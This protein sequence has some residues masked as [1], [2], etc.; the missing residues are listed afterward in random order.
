MIFIKQK[1]G[2][3]AA[4]LA[5]T[6]SGKLALDQKVLWF[7]S[8][9]S[10]IELEV[11]AREQIES[12]NLDNLTIMLFDERYGPDGH[13][14]SNWQQLQ[15]AGFDFSGTN[16][17]PVLKG[18]SLAESTEKFQDNLARELKRNDFIIATAGVGS[19]GHTSGLLPNCPALKSP[20]LAD[21]Y[22][23]P[24]YQRITTTPKAIAQLNEAVVGLSGEEKLAVLEKLQANVPANEMP[25]QLLKKLPKFIVFNDWTGDSL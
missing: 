9:G 19:D 15:D 25:A 18:L 16:P 22:E 1:P 7:L 3:A 17:L 4:Y 2:Q 21:C 6:I 23:G 8:G 24:D 11:K 5:Q 12:A 20:E 13:A 10:S 14:D